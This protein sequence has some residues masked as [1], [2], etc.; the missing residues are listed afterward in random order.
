MTRDRRPSP[1]SR[2]RKLRERLLP[3]LSIFGPIA[4]YLMLHLGFG[5]SAILAL[6]TGALVG[7]ATT[8][9][10]TIMQGRPNSIAILVIIELVASVTLALITHNPRILLYKPAVLL[11]IIGIYLLS[12]CI[13]GRPSA[14]EAAL[15]ALNRGDS[16]RG[17]AF[18]RA[19]QTL[20]KVRSRLRMMTAAWG[21]ALL[22]G[23]GVRVYFA[24]TSSVTEAVIVPHV[25]DGGL[26]AIAVAI[27]IVQF[28][29]V[30]RSI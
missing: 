17:A 5:L 25:I 21:I 11:S 27:A 18:E 16:D 8:I 23:A 10:Q 24:Q 2:D 29:A 6:T 9:L 13:W 22:L 20:P 14:Y 1:V 30:K 15:S 19:Y 7:V 4:V 12:T 26:I 3:I 28:R